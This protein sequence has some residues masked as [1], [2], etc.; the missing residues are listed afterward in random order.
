MPVNVPKDLLR[1]ARR[2][3]SLVSVLLQVLAEFSYRYFSDWGLQKRV[4]QLQKIQGVEIRT[5]ELRLPETTYVRTYVFWLHPA[6]FT[7]DEK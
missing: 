5:H 1:R 3:K 7:D 6:G 2:Q 4:Q